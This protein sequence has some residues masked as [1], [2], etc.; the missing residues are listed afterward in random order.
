MP[1]VEL[2]SS[3]PARGSGRDTVSP[4]TRPGSGDV[5]YDTSGAP[6]GMRVAGP[7][8]TMNSTPARAPAVEPPRA[9][10]IPPDTFATLAG[11]GT[12]P[13]PG[14]WRTHHHRNFRADW[15]AAPNAAIA[16]V[17]AEITGGSFAML[18]SAE[19]L[20]ATGLSRV[21]VGNSPAIAQC[22]QSAGTGSTI[23]H[24]PC[25]RFR[26]R[27]MSGRLGCHHHRS[28]GDCRPATA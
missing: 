14:R 3:L 20:D 6:G 5:Q 9:Q 7:I 27:T 4:F 18:R 8:P 11:R 22:G 10:R 16:A 12:D 13:A 25:W 23:D 24:S 26:R 17:R 28:D 21:A 15:S 2:A 1:L 19:L